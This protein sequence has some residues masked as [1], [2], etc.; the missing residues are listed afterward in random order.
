M[1]M[2]IRIYDQKM[3]RSADG[4]ILYGISPGSFLSYLNSI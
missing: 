2:T 4:P 3:A 1:F